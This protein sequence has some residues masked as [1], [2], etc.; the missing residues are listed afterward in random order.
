MPLGIGGRQYG[1]ADAAQPVQG[2]DG[3]PALI[4]AEPLL[5][6]GE[7]LVAAHEM[8]GHMHRDVRDRNSLAGKARGLR[9]LALRHEFVEAQPRRLLRHAE[10]F[11]AAEMV[12]ERRQAARFDDD[13]QHKGRPVFRRLPQRGV[14]LEGRIG[15]PQIFV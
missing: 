9:R 10:Q 2:G 1:L 15:R 7:R 8:F 12:A 5:D 13:K 6:R 14:A 4:A 11:T 3:D